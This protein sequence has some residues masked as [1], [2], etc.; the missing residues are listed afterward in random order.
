MNRFSLVFLS[1][2]FIL[3]LFVF[4][5]SSFIPPVNAQKD[6]ACS[7]EGKDKDGNKICIKVKTAIG[8]INPNPRGFVTAIFGLVMGLS[9]GIAL[10]LIMISGYKFMTS[11][12][13]PE[14]FQAAKDMLT[15][16][17]VGL[18]FIIFSFVILQVIGVDILHIPRFSP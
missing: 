2:L 7:Q 3:L 14:S 15:S 18:L 17:I 11:G 10:V 9:G 5:Q 4:L 12:N 1:S 16:A 13:N 8:D 6:A